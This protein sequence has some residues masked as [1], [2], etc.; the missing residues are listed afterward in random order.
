[1]RSNGIIILLINVEISVI[2]MA[3]CLW[4]LIKLEYN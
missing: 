1:M 4:E 2:K 3:I